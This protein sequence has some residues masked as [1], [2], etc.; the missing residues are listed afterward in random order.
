MR[1]IVYYMAISIDGYIS[2]P[3]DDI[4]GFVAECDGVDRYLKDLLAI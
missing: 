1:A 3:E 2:G 4:S